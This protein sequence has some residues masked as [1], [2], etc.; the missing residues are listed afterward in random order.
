MEEKTRSQVIAWRG[1]S[2]WKAKDRR[3]GCVALRQ[4]EDVC[5]LLQSTLLILTKQ[6]RLLAFS[7]TCSLRQSRS[8]LTAS[9]AKRSILAWLQHPMPLHLCIFLH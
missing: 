4:C 2:C 5:K 1:V 6:Y 3:F 7:F 8:S 9:S